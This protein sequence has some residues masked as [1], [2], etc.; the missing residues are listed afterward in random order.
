M[1][2]IKNSDLTVTISPKGAELQS[3]LDKNA[4]EW[5]WQGDPD[6]WSGQAPLLFPVIGRLGDGCYGHQGKIYK[7]NK[8]GFARDMVFEMLTQNE[9]S[10]TFQLS[11]TAE[12]RA[13]YPFSFTL[14]VMY[15]LEGNKLRRKHRVTNRGQGKMYYELGGHDAYNLCFS[16][17]ETMSDCH[18]FLPKEESLSVWDFDENLMLSSVKREI[19]LTDALLSVKPCDY[20]LD[21]LI[22]D[23]LKERSVAL[24]DGKGNTRIFMEFS[25]FPIFALWTADKAVDTN[26]VCMEPWTSLPD[27]GFMGRDLKDKQG[28]RSLN[29]GEEEEFSFVTTF[30]LD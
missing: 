25:D 7:I 22:L 23:G 9:E 13:S 19:P 10:I 27:G 12:T 2:R 15:Q 4:R 18:F 21:T 17:R 6:I 20:S 11:D 28:V 16:D 29:Q 26:Y 24:L 8:H 30:Y 1:Y 3:I 5:L 14:E